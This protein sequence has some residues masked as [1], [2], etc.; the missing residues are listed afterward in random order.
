[1]L[2][3]GQYVKIKYFRKRPKHWNQNGLMDCWM[4][5]QVIIN[6]IYTKHFITILLPGATDVSSWSF[7]ESDFEIAYLENILF[8]L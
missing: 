7:K 1:M 6:K 8:E 4:G 3:A 2:E 5:V